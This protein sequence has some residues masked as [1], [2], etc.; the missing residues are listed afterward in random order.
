LKKSSFG[1]LAYLLKAEPLRL[2]VFA[3]VIFF[4]TF[5]TEDD[6]FL[7]VRRG[8]HDAKGDP[9]PLA[10]FLLCEI[11]FFFSHQDA[12]TQRKILGAMASC[13]R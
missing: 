1:R 10:A 8:G 12:E 7:F 9:I 4:C 3:R 11:F 5:V 13:L 2:G 6:F